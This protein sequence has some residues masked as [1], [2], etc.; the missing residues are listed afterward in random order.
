MKRASVFLAIPVLAYSPVKDKRILRP[1]F[2][3]TPRN[4]RNNSLGFFP[5]VIKIHLGNSVDLI[6]AS[7]ETRDFALKRRR[8]RRR[9]EERGKFDSFRK[10][11]KRRRKREEREGERN[12]EDKIRFH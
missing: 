1:K 3:S 9:K 8:R 2:V 7:S 12:I 6:A 4:V 5:F 10:K 11:E